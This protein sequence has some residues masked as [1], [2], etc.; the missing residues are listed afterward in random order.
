MFWRISYKSQAGRCRRAE[1]QCRRPKSK[2]KQ[3]KAAGGPGEWNKIIG[4]VFKNLRTEVPVERMQDRLPV[5]W[6]GK[7]LPRE[8]LWALGIR[9]ERRKAEG[10][11]GLIL[12]G[13]F[14]S[15]QITETFRHSRSVRPGYSGSSG[16]FSARSARVME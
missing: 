9:A 6:L 12:A 2:G 7:H 3:G 8:G 10:V 11:E 15:R 4:T 14:Y 5:I 16:G 13:K 1:E